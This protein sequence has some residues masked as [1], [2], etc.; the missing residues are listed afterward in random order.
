MSARTYEPSDNLID[1]HHATRPAAIMALQGNR[2]LETLTSQG[3]GAIEPTTPL[4]SCIHSLGQ[5]TLV[6]ALSLMPSLT[7]PQ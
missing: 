4:L 2:G 5:R 6:C 3:F 7:C 1:L